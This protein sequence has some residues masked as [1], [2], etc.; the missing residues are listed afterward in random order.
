MKLKWAEV[1]VLEEEEEKEESEA[2]YTEFLETS[3]PL[4]KKCRFCGNW[5]DAPCMIETTCDS[6]FHLELDEIRLKSRNRKN[7]E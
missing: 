5:F 7:L 3:V 6:C 2:L 4:H 1:N